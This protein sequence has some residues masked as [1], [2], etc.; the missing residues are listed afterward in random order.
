M[1]TYAVCLNSSTGQ[2]MNAKEDDPQ[3]QR[4]LKMLKMKYAGIYVYM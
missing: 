3:V 2:Y 1:L 4:I